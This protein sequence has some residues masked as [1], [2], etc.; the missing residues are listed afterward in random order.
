M[1]EHSRGSVPGAHN[2][3]KTTSAKAAFGQVDNM[4]QGWEAVAVVWQPRSMGVRR[5]DNDGSACSTLTIDH[6]AGARSE[7]QGTATRDNNAVK[8]E[9][10]AVFVLI[11]FVEKPEV[12]AARVNDLKISPYWGRLTSLDFLEADIFENEDL[13]YL[14]VE[15]TA[16]FTGG[17]QPKAA[18]QEMNFELVGRVKARQQ[19]AAAAARAGAKAE[20]PEALTAWQEQARHQAAKAR[21]AA[22]DKQK[23]RLK[24]ITEGAAME[25]WI[26]ELEDKMDKFGIQDRE[27]SKSE[28]T[29]MLKI[30]QGVNP[31]SKFVA[32][33][34]LFRIT[35]GAARMNATKVDIK[36]EK[37]QST[38]LGLL[39]ARDMVSNFVTGG[40]GR[41]PAQL[42]LVISEAKPEGRLP[43]GDVTTFLVDYFPEAPPQVTGI[44][45]TTIG[46]STSAVAPLPAVFEAKIDMAHGLTEELLK[47]M[48]QREVKIGG[49]WCNWGFESS[50]LLQ[51]DLSDVTDRKKLGAMWD[52]CKL[53]NLSIDDFNLLLTAQIR[54]SVAG[55]DPRKANLI[56]A[57]RVQRQRGSKEAK[58]RLRPEE[59]IRSQGPGIQVLLTSHGAKEEIGGLPVRIYMGGTEDDNL[60]EV[61]TRIQVWEQSNLGIGNKAARDRAEERAKTAMGWSTKI[62]AEVLSIAQNARTMLTQ[63]DA[64]AADTPDQLGESLKQLQLQVL[65][66]PPNHDVT[67][68]FVSS[69]L[70]NALQELG[71]EPTSTSWERLEKLSKEMMEEVT[72]RRALMGP[73]LVVALGPFPLAGDIHYLSRGHR[74]SILEVKSDMM[75]SIEDLVRKSMEVPCLVAVPILKRKQ[76]GQSE[77]DSGQGVIVVVQSLD[78]LNERLLLWQEGEEGQAAGAS[79]SWKNASLCEPKVRVD[80]VSS[81][82]VTI[83]V[84]DGRKLPPKPVRVK[85]A[86]LR[87]AEGVMVRPEVQE[88]INEHLSECLKEGEGIWVPMKRAG[89]GGLMSLTPKSSGGYKAARIS[90]LQ[91]LPEGKSYIGNIHEWIGQDQDA[92]DEALTVLGDLWEK[93]VAKPMPYDEDWIIFLH[94]YFAVEFTTGDYAS[95]WEEQKGFLSIGDSVKDTVINV[96]RMSLLEKLE[97]R[98]A[99]GV[100][101]DWPLPEKNITGKVGIDPS[102]QASDRTGPR[103]IYSLSCALVLLSTAAKS[104]LLRQ[105]VMTLMHNE[106][107]FSAFQ[108]REDHTL[109]MFKGS[110]YESQLA[111]CEAKPGEPLPPMI[112]SD[113]TVTKV[114]SD[115]AN[116]VLRLGNTWE[117]V[118]GISSRDIYIKHQNSWNTLNEQNPEDEIFRLRRDDRQALEQAVGEITSDTVL[119]HEESEQLRKFKPHQQGPGGLLLV[120]KPPSLAESLRDLSE[121]RAEWSEG[122]LGRLTAPPNV[123]LLQDALEEKLP[124]LR[125]GTT[126]AQILGR[127][128]TRKEVT[129]VNVQEGYLIIFAERMV[130]PITGTQVTVQCEDQFALSM[131]DFQT[132]IEQ[133]VSRGKNLSLRCM[134]AMTL[135]Q[136]LSEDAARASVQEKLTERP[137]ILRGM[138]AVW[139]QGMLRLVFSPD[140]S[141]VGRSNIDLQAVVSHPSVNDARG[142]E[143]IQ[144][145]LSALAGNVRVVPIGPTGQSLLTI[146]QSS[147]EV[148]VTW[149]DDDERFRQWLPQGTNPLAELLKLQGSSS[150]SDHTMEGGNSNTAK[151]KNQGGQDTSDSSATAQ[152]ESPEKQEGERSKARKSANDE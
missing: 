89:E 84:R 42:F 78:Q 145:C 59:I 109:I 85:V 30:I 39:R 99:G 18:A 103:W 3:E 63:D 102:F 141:E 27:V 86:V 12:V 14:G 64:R 112:I 133:A 7:W 120:G 66:G 105:V 6:P 97:G 19:A 113:D 28:S 122:A 5:A 43:K 23:Q 65:T 95:A 73:P 79:P 48:Q 4:G 139:Q 136:D 15:D 148:F 98:A 138:V 52:L 110:V 29:K 130:S 106:G 16:G 68:T 25:E 70:C 116:A 96:A 126:A 54:A 35:E 134:R 31:N 44:S 91:N 101:L 75:T 92:C 38:H 37:T 80:T 69:T 93:G 131:A 21:L 111:Q 34:E 2:S 77:W 9:I 87:S 8:L 107:R 53:M 11:Y 142:P 128:Q 32:Q 72:S 137:T 10:P 143:L 123:H 146:P 17:T 33:S 108:G 104:T 58:M 36:E 151:R 22:E 88:A 49:I 51:V 46:A 150:A 57:A 124:E 135:A 119:V 45:V 94:A 41:Q 55:V 71:Q 83:Q 121:V 90:E 132:R 61:S 129:V 81:L 76:D 140:V 26:R 13:D 144:Q 50:A 118:G 125:Y 115:I 152:A 100:W 114:G 60:V 1:Q 149:R 82:R 40:Q 127:M 74:A 147:T 62:L 117:V 47:G 24:E 56:V 20:T 67:S